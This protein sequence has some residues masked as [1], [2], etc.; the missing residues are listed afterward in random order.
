MKPDRSNYEIWFTDFFDGNLSELQVEELKAF[1]LENPDLNEELNGLTSVALNP[2]DLAFTGKKLLGK[3]AGSLSEEQFEYLCI[4][5]LENDLKPEQK[6]ELNEIIS[7]DEIRRKSF[8]RIQKL[9]LKPVSAGFAR[10]NIVKKLTTGQKIFRLSVIGLSAAATIG[11]IVSLFLFK[12]ENTVREPAQTAQIITTDTI[13]AETD[14]PVAVTVPETNIVRISSGPAIRKSINE[15]HVSEVNLTLTEQAY[16]DVSDSLAVFQRPEALT[17]LKVEIPQD[18]F[19]ANNQEA[20]NIRINDPLYVPPLIEY[21]SNVQLFLARL[22][23]EKIMKDKNAGTRPVESFEIAQAG[24]KGLNKLFGWEIA[25]QK[26]T[27][28]SGDIRS[29]NFS[30]GLLKF[31]APVK[32]PVKAL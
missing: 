32:K 24:I 23:H 20:G 12:Y 11:I 7:N 27:D 17:S 14:L 30:S 29:Y 22:F 19:A 26:N 4:A 21:R 25:L 16:R 18:L 13:S 3:S 2:P 31:N 8:V 28:E 1:L 10:K 6:S 5:N 9:K 15:I